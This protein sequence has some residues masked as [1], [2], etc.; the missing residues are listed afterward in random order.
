MCSQELFY[1]KVRPRLCA[2]F[3]L[4]SR[5]DRNSDE[6]RGNTLRKS[7]DGRFIFGSTRGSKPGVRGFVTAFEL[8]VKGY[9]KSTD[10]VAYYETPTSGGIAG[11]IEPAHWKGSEGVGA[12]DYMLLVDEERGFVRVLG[13]GGAFKRFTEIAH[14]NLPEGATASHAIWLS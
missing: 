1:H 5:A 6:Y 14:T 4:T 8:D 13:W 10:A 9:L 7:R 12:Q 11:A 2:E 3:A